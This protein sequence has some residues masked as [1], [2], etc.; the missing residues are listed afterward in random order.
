MA[1]THRK[2]QDLETEKAYEVTILL[3]KTNGELERVKDATLHDYIDPEDA[4]KEVLIVAKPVFNMAEGVQKSKKYINPDVYRDFSDMFAIFKEKIISITESLPKY[5]RRKTYRER[6]GYV[7]PDW[8]KFL[9]VS[10]MEKMHITDV[11]AKMSKSDLRKYG[12]EP[13][14]LASGISGDAAKSL[15]QSGDGDDLIGTD[16]IIFLTSVLARNQIYVDSAR[17]LYVT[18][19]PDKKIVIGRMGVDGVLYAKTI[20]GEKELGVEKFLG[21]KEALRTIATSRKEFDS[22][23]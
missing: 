13:V 20:S 11:L 22:L 21:M 6:T 18:D 12:G 1:K 16:K 2:Y 23:L 9:G 10:K 19:Y 14:A 17:K 15:E 5:E 4:M 7:R 8:L 3:D